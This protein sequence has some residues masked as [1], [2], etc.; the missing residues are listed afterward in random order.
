MTRADIPVHTLIPR[1][2]RMTVKSPI[3][4]AAV[5]GVVGIAGLDDVGDAETDGDAMGTIVEGDV[6]GLDDGTVVGE[7]EGLTDGDAVGTIVERDVEGLAVG[8]A[9]GVSVVGCDEG[10]NVVGFDDVGLDVYGSV[11]EQLVY[12]SETNKELKRKHENDVQDFVLLV[13]LSAFV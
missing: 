4:N 2:A 9:E 3:T 8:L 12:V 13:C 1:S 11:V 7:E 10:V 6:E 5:G